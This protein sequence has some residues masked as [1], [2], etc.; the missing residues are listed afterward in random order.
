MSSKSSAISKEVAYELVEQVVNSKKKFVVDFD[1][2]WKWCGYSSKHKAKEQLKRNFNEHTDYIEINEVNGSSKLIKVY[3]TT[4][5]AK[6]FGM[7]SRTEAGRAVRKYFIEAE[8]ELNTLLNNNFDSTP[9]LEDLRELQQ[10]LNKIVGN[11]QSSLKADYPDLYNS[12]YLLSSTQTVILDKLDH[13]EKL[14]ESKSSAPKELSST[15]RDK[16][17]SLTI[18][19]N[20]DSAAAAGSK[21]TVFMNLSQYCKAKSITAYKGLNIAMGRKLNKLCNL[22]EI[23]YNHNLPAVCDYPLWLL[24]SLLESSEDFKLDFESLADKYFKKHDS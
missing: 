8:R 22:L 9:S 10:L 6:E 24:D 21:T 1:N 17:D 3:T 16:K 20:Y 15:T 18:P 7:L 13:I 5:C 11:Q 4:D 14:L 23:P 12:L 19:S 2:L